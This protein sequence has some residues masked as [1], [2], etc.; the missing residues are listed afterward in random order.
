MNRQ[1]RR[2]LFYLLE[3]LLL[4]KDDLNSIIS[5]EIAELQELRVPVLVSEKEQCRLMDEYI[6]TLSDASSS[7]LTC[8]DK[9]DG[10]LC[11]L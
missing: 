10:F 7:L 11:S 9:I 3:D 2:K 5:E 8:Y 1:C 4:L 6:L